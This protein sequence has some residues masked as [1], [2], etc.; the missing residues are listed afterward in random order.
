MR[1]AGPGLRWRRRRLLKGG[2]LGCN[3]QGSAAR[4]KEVVKLVSRTARGACN[5]CLLCVRQH[6]VEPGKQRPLLGTLPGITSP[7]NKP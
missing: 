6:L 5:L 7:E 1:W 3:R 4:H 2:E